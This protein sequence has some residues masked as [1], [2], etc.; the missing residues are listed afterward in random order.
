MR[1]F[2]KERDQMIPFFF[3]IIYYISE[4][5]NKEIYPT[6]GEIYVKVENDLKVHVWNS[7]YV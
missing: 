1:N 3:L 6:K 4:W 2:I 7:L 5:E